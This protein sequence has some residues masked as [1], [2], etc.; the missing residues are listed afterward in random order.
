[1]ASGEDDP[2]RV[3]HTLVRHGVDFVIV[4]GV[5]GVLHGAPIT[6]FDLDLVHARTDANV[7][8][9]LAA[10]EELGARYRDPAGRVILPTAGPLQSA[11]H[12]LLLTDAGPL[13]LLGELS[14]GGDYADLL[15]Q[16]TTVALSDSV[17]VRMLTLE[18]LIETKEALA[19][20]K[21]RAA[22]AVLRNTLRERGKADN[23][24]SR[25]KSE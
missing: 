19:R 23:Q 12:Q 5:C 22:L 13:D 8:R 6:T 18:A 25:D 15:P 17:S 14:T 2:L 24:P 20:D 3:L 9:L 16:T 11:G 21:D 4:G 10:L 1:M 7:T